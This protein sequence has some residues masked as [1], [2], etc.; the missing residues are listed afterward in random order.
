MTPLDWLGRKTSTQT[1]SPTP[2]HIAHNSDAAFERVHLLTVDKSK[3]VR[4]MA[5]NVD[6]DQTLRFTAIFAESTLIIKSVSLNA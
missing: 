3:T 6:L 1:S 5:N 2:Q 4:W